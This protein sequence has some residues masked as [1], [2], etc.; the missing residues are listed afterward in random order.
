ML[1]VAKVH[2]FMVHAATNSMI[3]FSD[4]QGTGNRCKLLSRF[5]PHPTLDLK[6]RIKRNPEHDDYAV[7]VVD[8]ILQQAHALG[9]TDVH[10]DKVD[11]ELRIRL[12]IDGNLTPMQILTDGDISQVVGRIKAL[13]KLITYRRDIPQEGR[14]AGSQWPSEVRVSTLPT[15][16]GERV[17]LRFGG[18]T[19]KAW[20]P[21]DLG[22]HSDV[23]ERLKQALQLPSGVIVICGP[24]GS[25]K[26][27]TAYAALRSICGQPNTR[28]V[29]TLEDPM[30]AEI[31]DVSQSEIDEA[32]GYSWTEGLKA[33]TRQDP[34]V[35]FVGEIRDGETA[36]VVFQAAL[37]GQLVITT[38][39]ARSCIDA[40]IR[41]IDLGVPVTHLATALEL[42]IC[43]RLIRRRCADCNTDASECQACFGTGYHGRALLA[44]VLPRIEGDLSRSIMQS[45]S[46]E[47]I[48]ESA[49]RTTP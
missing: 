41:F 38:L 1:F 7:D 37:M 21:E 18:V 28:S 19:A 22:L 11:G 12:R 48:L 17:V 42:L 33:L 46:A 26:T 36:R 14:I 30:E 10:I 2:D 45:G 35:M 31:P 9:A 34:E 15:V 25:G 24:A 40:I 29:V 5:M 20:Y 23:H 44:E 16:R 47:S 39:H 13:A 4:C 32:A 49:R 27:S 8:V 43:Q 6:S 3:H